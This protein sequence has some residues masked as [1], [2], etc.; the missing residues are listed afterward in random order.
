MTTL[1]EL[2]TRKQKLLQELK[3]IDNAID[4]EHNKND[5]FKIENQISQFVSTLRN[6]LKDYVSNIKYDY[7]PV[8]NEVKLFIKHRANNQTIIKS[9]T[10]DTYDDLISKL[11]NI[12][13]NI[14]NLKIFYS[15]LDNYKL[16][17]I[18]NIDI[19][20]NTKTINI[21]KFEF[22]VENTFNPKY[23][24]VELKYKGELEIH[25][26]NTCDLDITIIVSVE[27][28]LHMRQTKKLNNINYIHTIDIERLDYKPSKIESKYQ[29]TFEN[30]KVSEIH[31]KINELENIIKE[32][33]FL[34][35][36]L[37]KMNLY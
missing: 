19:S 27:D 4:I 13:N 31:K 33:D 15:L 8:N 9:F 14:N 17:Y 23:D 11:N 1:A 18:D 5:Q 36:I 6:L 21:C 25:N 34:Y 12:I 32:K 7:Y 20:F 22:S 37:M 24:Y 16:G 29:T 10:G 2:N 3:E 30:I 26:N 35:E 28:D